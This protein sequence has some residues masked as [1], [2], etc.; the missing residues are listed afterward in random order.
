MQDVS[1][2]GILDGSGVVVIHRLV[3]T[4]GVSLFESAQFKG[5]LSGGGEALVAARGP[6]VLPRADPEETLLAAERSW[7]AGG[8]GEGCSSEYVALEGLKRSGRL[9]PCPEI[10]LFHA[11]TFG[12]ELAARLT[13]VQLRGSLGAS[14]RCVAIPD[15]DASDPHRLRARLGAVLHQVATVLREGDPDKTAFAPL[16]DSK[17]LAALG[18][19]VSSYCGYPTL[20]LHGPGPSLQTL[21]WAPIRWDESALQQAAPLLRRIR[22]EPA[23]WFSLSVEEQRRVESLG[24]LFEHEDSGGVSWVVLSAFGEFLAREE[25]YRW[26]F[27]PRVMAADSEIWAVRVKAPELR[28]HVDTLLDWLPFERTI[29]C[30]EMHRESFFGHTGALYSLFDQGEALR[31]AWRFEEGILYLRRVWVDAD[32][33]YEY[34]ARTGDVLR[35]EPARWVEVTDVISEH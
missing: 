22:R 29:R 14:V 3:A 6:F 18:Y 25:A 16:G 31:L 12:G 7:E 33:R 23:A 1:G 30:A 17:V 21:P 4:S 32:G 24:W 34:E 8:L 26:L 35:W 28:A 13:S 27:S 9:S 2:E 20:C 15:L 5:W 11:S 10:V 19:L